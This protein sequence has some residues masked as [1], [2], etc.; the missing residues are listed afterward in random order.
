ML[1]VMITLYAINTTGLATELNSLGWPLDIL[2][3]FILLSNSISSI[4][5][6]AGA[7]NFQ[8]S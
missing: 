7:Q 3:A 8:V 1:D 6:F 2:G 4:S 5:L